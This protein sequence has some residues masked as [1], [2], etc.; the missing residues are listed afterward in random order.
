MLKL[1][2]FEVAEHYGS[3]FEKTVLTDFFSLHIFLSS[4]GLKPAKLPGVFHG[5]T[6]GN[7]CTTRWVS[8]GT[9]IHF[10]WPNIDHFTCH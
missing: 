7:G 10:I 4:G 3:Y 8:A 5:K 6:L 1:W 9:Q 2:L